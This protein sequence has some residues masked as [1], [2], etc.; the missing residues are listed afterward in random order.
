MKK[1][2]PVAV[3]AGYLLSLPGAG[4][5]QQP[6]APPSSQRAGSSA[7]QTVQ[8]EAKSLIGSTVRGQD[9]K[10]MGRVANIMIDPRDGKVSGIVVSM[11]SKL[12]IGGTQMTVPW[13]SVQIA[14]DQQSLVVT[15]QQQVMPTAPPRQDNRGGKGDGSPS[16]SPSAGS[17]EARPQPQS[18]SK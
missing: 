10:D 11:G 3:V 7:P 6:S 8:V 13:E 4:L 12:G 14:R 1:L 2:L 15:L 17:P 5:A 18:P 16:A 9:G